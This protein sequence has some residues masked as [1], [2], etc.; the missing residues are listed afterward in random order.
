MFPVRALTV[1]L[2]ATTV[3]A[4]KVSS[5]GADTCACLTW[6]EVYTQKEKYGAWCGS[7]RELNAF[8][9]TPGVESLPLPIKLQIYDEFCH[10]LFQR[11]DDNFCVN[12][13]M[14]PTAA[15]GDESFWASYVPK[16][17]GLQWCY[18]SSEC[19]K[20]GNGTK[21]NATNIAY[22][23]CTPDDQKL[24]E[25]SPP[26]L[27]EKALEKDL[28]LGLLAKYG[29]T[30]PARW[31]KLTQNEV[32]VA[33]RAGINQLFDSDDGHPT[34]HLISANGSYYQINMLPFP[35]GHLAFVRGRMGKVNGMS[36]VEGC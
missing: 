1:F 29:Y 34:F 16:N 27:A 17:P 21:V 6:K 36:C 30:T 20:L 10:K 32:D 5:Q 31:S 15:V 25:I 33:K 3:G 18:V 13:D 9:G 4:I 11:I 2:L 19:T 22:K 24:S 23:S 35:D 28:D 26:K 8:G 12:W 7:G 14:S